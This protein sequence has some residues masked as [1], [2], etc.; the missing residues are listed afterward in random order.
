M[1]Q[2]LA[3]VRTL[4][5]ALILEPREGDGTPEQVWG[6]AFCY[7]A[8]D[9]QVPQTVQPYA[10]VVTKDYPGDTDSALDAPGRW[11]VNVHVDRATFRAFTGEEP[12]SLALPRDHAAADVVLPHPVYGE[13]GWLCVVNPA[14]RTTETLHRLLREAHEAATA[15]VLRRRAAGDREQTGDHE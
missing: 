14:A 8:P 12:R 7:Y 11:R 10:T 15:R 13:L 2:I 1:E 9:G 5:G 3:A 6:D 4:P